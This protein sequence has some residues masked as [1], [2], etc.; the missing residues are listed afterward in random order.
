M[1]AAIKQFTSTLG[2]EDNFFFL[3]FSEH[4]SL[5]TDFVPSAD[6]VL[7]H[8]HFVK[9]GG[10]SSLYDSI[11]LAADRLKKSRNLKKSL[12]VISDG[13]DTSS[14]HNYDKLANA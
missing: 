11:Y 6:Q 1:L 14:I 8:L 9:P 13:Q 12:L 10:P 4:G 7:D 2:N 3:A 5:V